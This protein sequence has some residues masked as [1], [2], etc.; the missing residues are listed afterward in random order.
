MQRIF[1]WYR[2]NAGNA[3]S[4]AT[5]TV[6]QAG[7]Q[8]PA[9]IYESDSNDTP[10]S[11]KPNPFTTD[12]N[13]YWCF[14]A[15]VGDYDIKIEGAGN[16]NV[17]VQRVN[18]FDST[19][20]AGG[21]TPDASGVTYTH[22]GTGAVTRTV[23][24]KFEDQLVSIKDFGGAGDDSTDNT[25]ALNLAATYCA[26]NNVAGIWFPKGSYKFLSKPN[27]FLSGLNLVGDSQATTYFKRHYTPGS[28][29]EGFLTWNP[30][31]SYSA[32]GGIQNIGLLASNNA[33]G[34]ALIKLIATAS[35]R[36]GFMRFAGVKAGSN[37]AETVNY[38]VY[39]DGSA[40]TTLGSNGIRDI[41]F[42]DCWFFQATTHTVYI[43]NGVHV[44]FNN[45]LVNTGSG[46]IADFFITGGGGVG[47]TNSALVFMTGCE[48]GAVTADNTNG[49]I[50]NGDSSSITVAA[51]VTNGSFVG[52]LGTISNSSTT[53]HVLSNTTIS[54][55]SGIQTTLNN[56]LTVNS[57]DVFLTNSAAANTRFRAS[58]LSGSERGLLLATS[59]SP[60]WDVIASSDAEV[61]GDSGSAFNLRA[62]N[63]AGST[64]DTPIS[65]ARVSAGTM[66]F[67]GSSNRPAVFN[68]YVQVDGSAGRGLRYA[69]PVA[70]AAVAVT[71]GAGPTGSTAGNPQGWIRVSIAGT[72][73]YI[74]F[75]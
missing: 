13:G 4:G 22:S 10:A 55:G 9:S 30:N 20:S 65:I 73:R 42:Q 59:G 64:I 16:S 37:V 70:N 53:T 1:N 15:P 14:A 43:N 31:G 2:D 6:Y 12:A 67:G 62:R 47:T 68:G 17:F 28:A 39:I 48:A 46:S 58:A 50:F 51:T 57:S 34:G 60:R 71:L 49:I 32:A 23:Y 52:N 18:L 41:N 27:D 63:D 72:D 11:G 33:N 29:T 26:T 3:I 38:N 61:G 54:A 40:F 25:P 66:T 8:T 36:P 19:A 74:P 35:T 69:N 24:T 44:Y 5:V 56:T 21:S 45:C 75:W 7:T